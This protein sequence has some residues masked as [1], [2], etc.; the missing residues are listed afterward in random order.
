MNR[1]NFDEQLQEGLSS[2]YSEVEEYFSENVNLLDSLKSGPF[3][4][5]DKRFLDEGGMKKIY[6]CKDLRS[7]RY[8]AMAEVSDF[9]DDKKVDDFLREARINAYLQ[10]PNIIPVYEI[11]LNEEEKPYFT[12]KFIQGCTLGDIIKRLREKDQKTLQEYPLPKLIN[13]FEKCCEAVSYA[14]SKG[15]VHLDLKPD[16]ISVSNFGEVLVCDWGISEPCPEI[17][18]NLSNVNE[19]FIKLL[20]LIRRDG[21]IRGTIQF[22]APEQINR[23]LAAIS[24]K[25]DIYSLGMVL[26]NI[27][28]YEVPIRNAPQKEQMIAVLESNIPLPSEKYPYKEIPKSLEAI[29]LKALEYNCKDR[30]DSVDEILQELN[31]FKGGFATQAEGASVFELLNL[32]YLRNKAV[33][34]IIAVTTLIIVLLTTYGFLEIKKSERIAVIEKIKAVEAN[35]KTMLLLNEVKSEQQ[36]KLEMASKAAERYKSNL[37][38]ALYFK[39]YKK[40]DEVIET[41]WELG[42]HEMQYRQ[43]YACYK[44]AKLNIKEALPLLRELEIGEEIKGALSH[45]VDS[46]DLS[47]IKVIADYLTD[48][49]KIKN[50]AGYF[51]RNCHSL[52]IPFEAKVQLLEWEMNLNSRG[53]VKFDYQ[54]QGNALMLDISGNNLSYPG[55]L[56]IVNINSLNISNTQINRDD[57]IPWGNI[58]YL[59]ISETRIT[60]LS[61]SDSIQE[62][63]LRNCEI[64]NLSVLL[65]MKNLER[66]DIRGIKDF[67]VKILLKM[68]K[69]KEVKMDL[70]HLTEELDK[71][72]QFR[73]VTN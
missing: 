66:I 22:M 71:K 21:Y 72:A 70:V 16:N 43:L 38:N 11:G 52:N 59:D 29:C 32:L 35:E 62:L 39:N 69:L 15:I 17:F 36:K 34:L 23:K 25:A 37:L 12:M 65:K 53:K 1:C 26:Y 24:P 46:P 49:L 50:L 61:A 40:S 18:D 45:I 68:R 55:S 51:L 6:T 42:S 58:R 28:T 57:V 30:Y 33:C 14:H 2:L 67:P 10:H 20:P 54:I 48:E 4:Y 9:K 60:R 56:D 31:R 27:L 5:S 7:D 73:I 41:I 13:I 3:P 63:I 64:K 44:V 19:E 47:N 8:V